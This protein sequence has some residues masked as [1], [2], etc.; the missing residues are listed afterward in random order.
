[1]ENETPEEMCAEDTEKRGLPSKLDAVGWGLFLIWVGIAFLAEFDRGIGLMGVGVI[2]V[3]VQVARR[4]LGL[5]IQGFWIFVGLLFVA[6]GLSE[7]LEVKL[8]LGPIVLVVVGVAFLLSAVRGKH[9]KG[10]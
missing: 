6:G 8:R 5:N 7:F 4:V 3:G 9:S 10:R 2:A 1:M